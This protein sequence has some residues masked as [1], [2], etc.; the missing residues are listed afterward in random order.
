MFRNKASFYGKELSALRPT[1]KPEEKTLSAVSDCLFNNFADTLQIVGRSSIRNLRTRHAVVTGTNSSWV[2]VDRIYL[3][4]I[5]DD[6]IYKN[7][8][9]N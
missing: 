9:C 6:K 3:F 4:G 7:K 5:S 2:L 8:H 1:R